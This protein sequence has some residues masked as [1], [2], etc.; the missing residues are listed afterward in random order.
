MSPD[1]TWI[2]RLVKAVKALGRMVMELVLA[3]LDIVRFIVV[4]IYGMLF[5]VIGFTI[6]AICSLSLIF[7]MVSF[8]LAFHLDVTIYNLLVMILLLL[9]RFVI[10]GETIVLLSKL[11]TTMLSICITSIA[12]IHFYFLTAYQE[13]L[14]GIPTFFYESNKAFLR[15]I[16]V[17]ILI[18]FAI[19][20]YLLLR[21]RDIS[22]INVLALLDLRKYVNVK[23]FGSDILNIL[24]MT[25]QVIALYAPLWA[26]G[27]G[28]LTHF[29]VYTFWPSLVQFVTFVLMSHEG[30]QWTKL[31]YE[32]L[33][34]QTLKDI[35]WSKRLMRLI[36]K[37]ASKIAVTWSCRL[38]LVEY[39]NFLAALIW[40]AT[41]NVLYIIIYFLFRTIL[42][43]MIVEGLLKCILVITLKCGYSLCNFYPTPTVKSFKACGLHGIVYQGNY[44]FRSVCIK[45][46]L[47]WYTSKNIGDSDLQKF[48]VKLTNCKHENVVHFIK[49]VFDSSI[50]SSPCY[51]LVSELMEQDLKDYLEANQGQ[52]IL[53]FAKGNN[54][55]FQIAS[56]LRYLHA[57]KPDPILHGRLTVHNVLV[58]DEG[59]VFKISDYGQSIIISGYSSLEADV[60]C[61][62][63]VML[64]IAIYCCGNPSLLAT[65]SLKY[66]S[67]SKKYLEDLPDDLLLK[68]I[69]ADSL[70]SDPLIRPSIAFVQD[71]L[72]RVYKGEYD[73]Q[74]V[75]SYI[76]VSKTRIINV[77]NSLCRI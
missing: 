76:K 12:F 67:F 77:H 38:I 57:V 9:C 1:R 20:K 15:I 68:P 16:P 2:R 41:P 61:L 48:C 49:A 56:G 14:S 42:L 23:S 26:L 50:Y 31:V 51:L 59:R 66:S 64:E 29:S 62:G 74:E 72:G 4:L 44:H 5:I 54:I 21:N 65:S 53:S 36:A 18:E 35:L 34:P 11:W 37:Y 32:N 8:L 47:P 69:I 24:S 22:L 7:F 17:A 71:V 60:F 19:H 3:F 13:S 39:L 58:G 46:M 73:I 55:S 27:F 70:E 25:F 43:A 33:I 28:T 63:T 52:K 30:I 40:N 10:S 75:E 45:R 6:I